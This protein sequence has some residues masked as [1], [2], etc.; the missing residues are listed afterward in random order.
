MLRITQTKLLP[1]HRLN[2]RINYAFCVYLNNWLNII[3]LNYS[4][5]NWLINKVF[6]K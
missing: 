6:G 2:G 5:Y 3:L 1:D 4:M